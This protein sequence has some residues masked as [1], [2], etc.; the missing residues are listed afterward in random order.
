VS[1]GETWEVDDEKKSRVQEKLEA[2]LRRNL[3]VA[4]KHRIAGEKLQAQLNKAK[5]QEHAA[6]STEVKRMKL[7]LEGVAR[8]KVEEKLQKALVDK[9]TA[10]SFTQQAGQDIHQR[11]DEVL[12]KLKFWRRPQITAWRTTKACSNKWQ[13]WR[14]NSRCRLSRCGLAESQSRKGSHPQ[15][16]KIRL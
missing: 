14:G 11:L 16:R 4:R 2:D 3:E 5:V 10:S 9:A 15:Q 12:A 13:H 1:Q 6:D 7:L 8:Q